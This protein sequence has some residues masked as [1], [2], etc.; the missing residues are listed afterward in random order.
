MYGE[1]QTGSE[2]GWSGS[3]YVLRQ[4][5]QDRSR[6]HVLV[7]PF[8]PSH[9]F[10]LISRIIPG[11]TDLTGVQAITELPASRSKVTTVPLRGT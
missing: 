10:F 8:Y 7:H 3:I 4:E 1:F 5:V 6:G 2:S 11:Y 9:F